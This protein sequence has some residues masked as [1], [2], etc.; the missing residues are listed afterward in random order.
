MPRSRQKIQTEKTNHFNWSQTRN[1]KATPMVT[2]LSFFG[3]QPFRRAAK[4]H[5]YLKYI[6]LFW[7]VGV[8]TTTEAPTNKEL[9]PPSMRG[10]AKKAST[11]CP[12]FLFCKN[13]H[14]QGG[15]PRSQCIGFTNKEDSGPVLVCRRA[16]ARKRG[17]R[18][19]IRA[20][21]VRIFFM[22]RR[23][24]GRSGGTSRKRSIA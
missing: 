13:E 14:R 9:A 8:Y 5:Y 4:P 19:G 7:N 11:L 10:F 21:R 3:P 12:M 17:N 1:K 24:P 6:T 22:A 20:S 18:E 16:P 2:I 23:L 15:S